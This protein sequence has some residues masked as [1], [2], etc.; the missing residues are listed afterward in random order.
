MI[1]IQLAQRHCRHANHIP[2]G[3][4]QHRILKNLDGIGRAALSA[5]F[6]QAPP[7]APARTFCDQRRRLVMLIEPLAEG[8]IHQRL[9]DPFRPRRSIASIAAA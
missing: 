1:A 8:D 9:L 7:P 4:S 3:V 5:I 6:V 2:L